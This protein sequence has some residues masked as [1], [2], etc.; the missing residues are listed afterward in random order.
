VRAASRFRLPG[1]LSLTIPD[2]DADHLVGALQPRVAIST[3]AACSSGTIEASHV[4]RAIGLI[5]ISSVQS[6]CFV[7]RTIR[8]V[9]TLLD[10][11]FSF[12][13]PVV[14]LFARIGLRGLRTFAPEPYFSLSPNNRAVILFMKCS[15]PQAGQLTASYKSG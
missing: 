10:L 14:P 8:N 3:S 12:G 5:A 13:L 6:T 1:S 11:F 9:V 7:E 2:V 15:R 4:L